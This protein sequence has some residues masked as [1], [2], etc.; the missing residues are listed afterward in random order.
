MMQYPEKITAIEMHINSAY[1]LYWY[2]AFFREYYYPPPYWNGSSWQYTTPWLWFDG[3][4]GS[5]DYLTWQSKIVNRMNQSASVTITIW[6]NYSPTDGSGTIYAK[7][8]NDFATTINGR[9]MFVI[10]EDSIYYAAPNLDN[11]HNHVARDYLPDWN[12]EIVAIP[13][14]DSVTISRAFTIQSVWNANKCNI[15]T[16]IQNDQLQADSTKEIWQG[17]FKRVSDLVVGMEE[18]CSANASHR[19]ISQMPNP[20][21]NQTCFM[22]S[23]PKGAKYLIGFFDVSGRCISTLKGTASGYAESVSWDCRDDR[24]QPVNAGVYF[25]RFQSEQIQKTGKLVKR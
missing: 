11:W 6:G 22:F 24:G 10:T 12:G 13:A 20:F 14:N 17:G 2:E 7:F 1:P 23:L 4:K 8:R 18:A 21:V 16:W 3:K 9:I 19:E 15:I 25:Y 5:V